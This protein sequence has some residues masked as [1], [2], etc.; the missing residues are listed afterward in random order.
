[1]NTRGAVDPSPEIH[2]SSSRSGSEP[3]QRAAKRTPAISA[4][5]R[6]TSEFV[7]RLDSDGDIVD[8]R[9]TFPEFSFI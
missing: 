7:N 9:R 3:K 5:Q 6:K 8:L 1:M 4:A 2:W